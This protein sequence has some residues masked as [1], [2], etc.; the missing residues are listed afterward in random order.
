MINFLR[1]TFLPKSTDLALLVLRFWLGGTMLI[2]HGLPKLT[3]FD[4]AAAKFPALFGLSSKINLG[5]AVF[6]EAVCSVLIILGVL[7]R[8]AALSQAITMGVAFF[9]VH[10]AAL[11]GPASGEL[12]FLY[13]GGCITLLVAGAGRFAVDKV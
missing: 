7:S 5:L 1:F 10:K 9:M 4:A 13:L 2:K 3:H 6:G 8:F 12:A 11:E